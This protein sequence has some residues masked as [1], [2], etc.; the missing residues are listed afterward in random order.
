MSRAYD[1]HID[2][3]NAPLRSLIGTEGRW[4]IKLALW[5]WNNRWRLFRA[6]RACLKAG[7]RGIKAEPRDHRSAFQH[8]IHI[9]SIRWADPAWRL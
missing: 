6:R 3:A 9:P 5:D 2:V 8:A 4:T 7:K 1:T